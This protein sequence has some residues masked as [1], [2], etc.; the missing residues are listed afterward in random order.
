[1]KPNGLKVR[2]KDLTFG[3]EKC[4]IPTPSYRMVEWDLRS[5]EVRHLA[6]AKLTLYVYS[7]LSEPKLMV[8]H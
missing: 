4:S 7:G 3:R 2:C 1:M 5:T 6:K 8:E